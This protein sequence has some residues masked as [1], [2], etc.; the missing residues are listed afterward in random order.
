MTDAM[1]LLPILILGNHLR[2]GTHDEKHD[3]HTDH[4]LNQ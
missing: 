3:Y 1:L 4:R 2:S